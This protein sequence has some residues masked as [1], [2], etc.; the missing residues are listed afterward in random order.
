MVMNDVIGL[1]IAHP[2]PGDRLRLSGF[3]IIVVKNRPAPTGRHPATG[4]VIQIAGSQKI[5][6]R[7]AKELKEAV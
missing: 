3:W 4:A 7:P 6:F 1:M 5:A 2:K